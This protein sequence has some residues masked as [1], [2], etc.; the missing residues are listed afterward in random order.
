MK[1]TTIRRSNV[2]KERIKSIE[3]LAKYR[4]R[5]YSSSQ[6]LGFQ[7]IKDKELDILWQDIDHPVSK[8]EKS[9]IVYI[10]TGFILGAVSM[11]IL[12][13]IV[14]L[15]M[16]A[17]KDSEFEEAP[18]PVSTTTD[19]AKLTFIPAD[20]EEVKNLTKETYT[21]QSGDNLESIVIRF[22]GSY[23]SKNAKRIEDANN[24]T[25]PNQL[26]LGQTLTIPLGNAEE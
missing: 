25:N 12:T 8:G 3:A 11:L 14:N 2:S 6:T 21:V 26:R 10:I 17:V 1:S 7:P 19:T 5:N 13:T 16:N 18:V 24:L 20:T 22:Y 15:S 9:P 23:S 4:R